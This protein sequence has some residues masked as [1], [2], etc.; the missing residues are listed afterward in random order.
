MQLQRA[1]LPAEIYNTSIIL[2]H[3]GRMDL[4]HRSGSA[5]GY[6]NYSAPLQAYPGYLEVRLR[7]AMTHSTAVLRVL[8]DD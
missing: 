7:R 3:W 5:W 1:S 8:G 6:D 4:Q 2:S